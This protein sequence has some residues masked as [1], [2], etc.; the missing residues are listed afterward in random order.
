MGKIAVITGASAG[1]GRAAVRAFAERGYDV[2]LLARGKA[3][4]EAAAK[5][6]EQHGGRSLVVPTDVADAEQVEAAAERVERELG[7]VDVWVNDA[8]TSVFAPLR[9]MTAEEFRRV[10]EVTYLGQVYGT[11]AALRRM[12]P[13][14]R[15]AIVLVGSAL[16]YR[17]IPLQSAYCGAKFAM[18]GFTDSVRTELLHDGSDVWITM[19]QLPALNTPQFGWCR[20]KLPNHPQPVPPIYQPEVAADAVYWAAHQRRREIDVGFSSVKAI[21]GN[22]IA[23]R[24]ADWYLARTG[25]KSQQI[26]DMPVERPAGNLFD[27]V[28]EGSTHGIFDAQ[29]RTRSY[30]LW[31]TT[32]RPLLAA[33]AAGLAGAVAGVTRVVRG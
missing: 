33:A 7:E 10:T 21:V 19:V 29:A 26:E 12:L 16:A 30:Q 23:P 18:R 11:M 28:P 8:M 25:F 13:R 20:T 15:G 31:A 2:A 3:G 14:D 1:V 9:E 4:L 6:V 22:K 27:P 32:H 5:E 24:F 17:G